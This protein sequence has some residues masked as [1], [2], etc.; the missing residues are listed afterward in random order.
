MQE[1]IQQP[2]QPDPIKP[3]AKINRLTVLLQVI[4]E[5]TTFNS[6]SQPQ[7]RRGDFSFNL[8]STEESY[9]RNIVVGETLTR[10]N[11]AW[12]NSPA[13]VF[14]KNVTEWE[15]NLLP[16]KEDIDDVARRI[17]ELGPK[18]KPD[19]LTIKPGMAQPLILPNSDAWIRCLHAEAK[20]ILFVVDR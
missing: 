20:L 4:H 8:E 2:E 19:W 15:G 13:L 5:S 17:V 3:P 14:I 11:L 18:E 7:E 10:L 16:T 12:I 6:N 9:K 1:M